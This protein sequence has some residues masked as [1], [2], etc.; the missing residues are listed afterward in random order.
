M[1]QKILLSVLVVAGSFFAIPL[2]QAQEIHQEFQ[3]LIKAEVLEIVD[4]SE[5]DIMGTG[6]TT[7]VQEL[8]IKLLDGVK[9]GEVARLEN[10]LV[11]LSV[12]DEIFVNRLE[13]IDGTEYFTFKDIERRPALLWLIIIFVVLVVGL[14]GKQGSAPYSVSG[15]V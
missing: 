14:S 8:R 7:T 13:S 11:V 1:A 9:A 2:A 3:E 6:A 10:D 12:G 5:R 15:L 4:E